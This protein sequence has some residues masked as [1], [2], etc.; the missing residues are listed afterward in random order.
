MK[1]ELA[2]IAAGIS[3]ILLNLPT[4]AASFDCGKA[5]T[6][7]EH[8]VCADPKLSLLDSLLGQ[9]FA[10]AKKSSA[11]DRQDTAR[12]LAVARAF[13]KQRQ[14]CASKRSC[15]VASYAGALDGY[16]SA[17]S[18]VQL[19]SWIDADAISGNRAPASETLPKSPGQCVSTRVAEVH[20]RLGGDGPVKSEDYDSGTAVEFDNGGHQ[21]SYSHEQALLAS[22]PGDSV[23]MCLISVPQACLPATTEAAHIWSPTPGRSRPGRCQTRSTCAGVLR[24]NHQGLAR[25]FNV[26]PRPD[27]GRSPAS[28]HCRMAKPPGTFD[29][30]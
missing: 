15:L 6:L 27:L 23:V 26:A 29:H 1:T 18:S 22:Q 13:L 12:V 4:R 10:E 24:T 8:A 9:A 7:E 16:M 5:A 20:P 28:G 25:S 19:P 3:A 14:G 21:V 11:S 30:F 17:G 2:A